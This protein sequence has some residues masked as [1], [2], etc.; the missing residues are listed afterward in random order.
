MNSGFLLLFRQCRNDCLSGHYSRNDRDRSAFAL[1]LQGLFLFSVLI[2][3]GAHYQIERFYS[4]NLAVLVLGIT[5]VA[6]IVAA[7]IH[8]AYRNTHPF[9]EGRNAYRLAAL[10][11]TRQWHDLSSEPLSA[12]SG[13]DALAFAAAF[14]SP[15]HPV[16]ARPSAYEL[17][18]GLARKTTLEKGWAALCF[19]EQAACIDWMGKTASIAS[20]FVRLEVVVQSTQLGRLGPARGIVALIALPFEGPPS[21]QPS[22]AE[23]F[24]ANRRIPT[25]AE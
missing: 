6:V 8:A 14:Y 18:W 22:N 17:T 23:D 13:D 5:L 21:L 19:A 1:V 2:V 11:L 20:R 3:C 24:S 9:E 25:V 15:D 16:Y 12:V 7:P 4:V 10:E